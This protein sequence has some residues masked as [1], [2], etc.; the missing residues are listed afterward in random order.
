LTRLSSQE[1]ATLAPEELARLSP[2]LA[3]LSPEELARLSPEQVAQA[4]QLGRTG[5]DFA[6]W[7]LVALFLMALGTVLVVA[8]RR[9]DRASA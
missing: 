2:Q 9:R 8:N 1:L 3:Q 6:P 4:I 7:V 5:T